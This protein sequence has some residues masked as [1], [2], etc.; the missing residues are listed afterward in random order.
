MS[1]S[2][3]PVDRTVILFITLLLLCFTISNIS[4]CTF[5]IVIRSVSLSSTYGT[6]REYYG[7]RGNSL[8]ASLRTRGDL[9]E[10]ACKVIVV[11]FP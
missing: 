9:L 1:M 6:N 2:H 11:R 8:V 3:S 10:R 5:V 7:L 4:A